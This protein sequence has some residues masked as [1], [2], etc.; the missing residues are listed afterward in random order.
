[1]GD[2]A[3]VFVRE[4][5]HADEGVYLYTH[6]GGAEL[7][8][9]VQKALKRA[10]VGGRTGDGPYLARIVF[11]EMLVGQGAEALTRTTG[12]GITTRLQDN[13][14]YGILVLDPDQVSVGFVKAGE[15]RDGRELQ[16]SMSE[17]ADDLDAAYLG[18]TWRA[19]R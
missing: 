8:V 14:S 11:C 9:T 5:G 2:R 3:N 6:W 19:A 16:W 1:M 10:V 17:Y 7:A 18:D 15:E 13:D 12:H 4:H